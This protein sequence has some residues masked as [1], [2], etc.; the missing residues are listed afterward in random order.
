MPPGLNAL[1]GITFI[2]ASE[3]CFSLA[4]FFTKLAWTE[5]QIPGAET[6]AFRFLLG[7]IF[8][9][10]VLA[11]RGTGFKPVRLDLVLLRGV[12]NST[13]L[14]VFA[15]ALQGTLLSKANT[16]N[17]TY[18]IFVFLIA[19][20]VTKKKAPPLGW[21][22]VILA[23]IGTWMVLAP[24]WSSGVNLYDVLGLASGV[25][26][27]FGVTSLDLARRHDGTFMI[28]FYMMGV[29]TVVAAVSWVVQLPLVG[30]A[31]P[32]GPGFWPFVGGCVFG[33]L[34]QVFITYG[35]GFVDARTGSVL[36][37]SRI[38]FATLLGLL[39]FQETLGPW[40]WAGIVLVTVAIGLTGWTKTG[41]SSKQP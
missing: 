10:V 20:F 13:A 30:T 25:I 14:V 22:L 36:S 1:R 27:A 37:S 8:A 5:G 26:A 4:S 16:L 41:A 11:R 31:L 15:F 6:T 35:Y 17:M 40:S 29:G 7:F 12:F 38:L 19:P 28:L 23:V 39:W 9:G 34:G 24:D 21:A 2:L 33:V 32:W 18:P 3:L